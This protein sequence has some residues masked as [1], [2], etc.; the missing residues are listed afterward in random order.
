[1]AP[2]PSSLVGMRMRTVCA[3]FQKTVK[4]STHVSSDKGEALRLHLVR[5]APV[6]A[7]RQRPNPNP[8]LSVAENC[9]VLPSSPAASLPSQYC[10]LRCPVFI[11]SS[12]CPS[13][14]CYSVSQHTKAMP[15]AWAAL[16]SAIN[17][18]ERWSHTFSRNGPSHTAIFL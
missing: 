6:P 1:M 13:V 4:W 8:S 7:R 2:R 9:C 15:S 12:L 10:D 14:K 5:T 11:Y 18:C 17:Y 3:Q 16:L